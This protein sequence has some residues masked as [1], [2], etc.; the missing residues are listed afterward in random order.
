VDYLKIGLVALHWPPNFGGAERY[1][2]RIIE[3]LN[4]NGVESWGIT[5]T[6]IKDNMD[7]GTEYVHRISTDKATN[8]EDSRGMRLWLDDAY[9]HIVKNGYTHIIVSNCRTIGYPYMDF[10]AKV[11][12]IGIKVG[13]SHFDL[14]VKIRIHLEE[15]FKEHQDWNVVEDM[16][17]KYVKGCF[18]YDSPLWGDKL[19]YWA[20]DSPLYFNPDFI[21]SCSEWSGRFIDPFNTKPSF[22]LHPFIE[23][24]QMNK[25]K[26][27][28]VN[29]TM[30]NPM[31]HKGR[32]YMADIV[33]DFNNDWTYRILLGGYGGHKE[34]FM[35]MIAD[36]WAIRDGRVDIRPYVERMEDVWESTD[37][38]IF[39]SRFEG[40]GMAAVEP[41]IHGVPVMVQNYPSVIEAVGEGGIIMPYGC[42]SREWVETIEELFF[43][44][45]EY[46]EIQQKGYERV[47]VLQDRQ[48]EEIGG[49]IKFMEK[50]V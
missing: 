31:Y 4:H 2:S 41:M 24:E 1:N 30:I 49:L 21:I 29:I 3:E 35:A 44:D 27:E 9:D 32:S 43:D 10:I 18:E 36:S 14:D 48:H 39:P 12:E 20:I 26:L 34:E 8:I 50:L 11:Q 15:L 7:N 17:M 46:G 13:V 38:F 40:Y 25:E 19:G 33:N 5:P 16:M 47:K 23:E 28:N 22:V 6:P 42:D 37:L 45:E